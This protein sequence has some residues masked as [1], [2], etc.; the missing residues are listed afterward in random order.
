MKKNFCQ[1]LRELRGSLTQAQYAEKIGSKQTTLSSWERGFREPNIDG[2]VLIATSCGVSADWLLGISD[3]R[4]GGAPAA[5]TTETEKK[6]VELEKENLA[7]KGEI[8]GLQFALDAVMKG[9]QVAQ[10]SASRSR[11]A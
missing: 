8:K 3:D 1:R 10:A 4:G 7:L 9:A 11:P 6:I 2:I 5:D